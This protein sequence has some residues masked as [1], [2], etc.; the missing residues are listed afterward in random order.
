MVKH[1]CPNFWNTHDE[2]DDFDRFRQQNVP[3]REFSPGVQSWRVDPAPLSHFT[4]NGR[5]RHQGY[6][7][8]LLPAAVPRASLS[9]TPGIG[10]RGI[11]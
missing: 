11:P 2:T 1:R 5:F 8:D 4:R 10:P 7:L 6:A 9:Q 3:A